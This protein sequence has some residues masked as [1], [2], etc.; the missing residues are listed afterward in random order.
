MSIRL[1]VFLDATVCLVDEH[2]ADA[3]DQQVLAL[4]GWDFAAGV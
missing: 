1:V 2:L 4:M 3:V